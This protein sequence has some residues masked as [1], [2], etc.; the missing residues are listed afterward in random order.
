MVKH[1][2]IW[3]FK[4]DMPAAER[5][6]AAEK[7]KSGLEGLIEKI[8]GL[9]EISVKTM[10]LKSSNGDLMLDSSFVDED[11]LIDYQQNPEH[12]KVAQFVRSVVGSRKCFDFED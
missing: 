3:N 1:I 12:L 8:D 11:A 9:V 4:E 7:I 5:A 10:P 2:I 6:A